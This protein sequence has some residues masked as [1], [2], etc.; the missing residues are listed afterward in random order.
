MGP[1]DAGKTTVTKQ[2]SIL[3]GNGFTDIIRE[4]TKSAVHQNILKNVKALITEME[5]QHLS[6]KGQG[7]LIDEIKQSRLE[8][9]ELLANALGKKIVFFLNIDL[10]KNLVNANK[11]IFG[12]DDNI[13]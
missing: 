10:I 3:L 9:G 5:S 11:F 12:F 6:L 4:E 7:E 1:A 13:K 2:M 8:D